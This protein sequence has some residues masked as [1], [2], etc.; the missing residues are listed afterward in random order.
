MTLYANQLRGQSSN[1]Q[2]PNEMF[3]ITANHE[4]PNIVMCIKVLFSG[5]LE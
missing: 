1:D 3:E 5:T 4:T 2:S